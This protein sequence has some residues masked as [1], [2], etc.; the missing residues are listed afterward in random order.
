MLQYNYIMIKKCLNCNQYII[1]SS[2][3]LFYF[4][5]Y[6]ND[7]CI[8]L[9]YNNAFFYFTDA[10]YFE[11]AGQ[12]VNGYEI[13]DISSFF[14]F[15]KKNSIKELGIEDSLTFDFYENLKKY[16]V[17]KTFFITNEIDELRSVKSTE[18]LEKIRKAQFV[19]DKSFTML[20][21]FINKGIT[22]KELS[23]KLSSIMYDNGADAL[24]FD[25]IVAFGEN[26]SKPHAHP[27][28]KILDCGMPI[29]VD[30]GAKCDNYCSDMTRTVFYSKPSEKIVNIYNAVRNAQ[31]TAL[32]SI[33]TG[34]TGKECD[35]IARN[36]FKS[37]NLDKFFKHSLGHSLGIDIH[38]KPTFSQKNSDIMKKNMVLSVEPGLYFE[39]EFGVRIEDI[40]YFDE[41][42][43][44]NLTKSEKNIII[45]E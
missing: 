3:N 19:T 9:K 17:E 31:T 39:N 27:T 37:I 42:G 29:T 4:T 18:E 11:E 25:N 45:I 15:I 1:T 21:K 38:E 2:S 26:T 24:A 12:N 44:I 6:K 23:H 30:F 22:E 43:I 41:K 14:E 32:S 8:I 16:G 10:R 13:L 28:D 36:Y 5:E 20:L 40:I 7:D 35:D 34:M 33:K